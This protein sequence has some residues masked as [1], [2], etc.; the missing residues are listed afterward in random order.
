[1]W[2]LAL[3]SGLRSTVTRLPPPMPTFPPSKRLKAV[4]KVE[5]EE[6]VEQE[7]QL[8]VKVGPDVAAVVDAVRNKVRVCRSNLKNVPRA[9]RA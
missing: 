5:V 8:E 1:M 6:K 3:W 7:I 2:T 9:K 4:G